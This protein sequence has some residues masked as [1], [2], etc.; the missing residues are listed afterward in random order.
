M[1]KSKRISEENTIV[2]HHSD[3]LLNK[4][5][6]QALYGGKDWMYTK[7]IGSL[8]TSEEDM[9]HVR[10]ST[11]YI[12]TG[13]Q[14]VKLRNTIH[15]L[16]NQRFH[17]TA[18]NG[19]LSVKLNNLEYIDKFLDKFGIPCTLQVIRIRLSNPNFNQRIPKIQS[20]LQIKTKTSETSNLNKT[21]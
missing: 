7:G 13:F 15:S 21:L 10:L 14:I 11:N 5:L 16:L 4:K 9:K 12:H 19:V 17:L 6:I 2:I 20:G 8:S 18:Y 3:P 1:R